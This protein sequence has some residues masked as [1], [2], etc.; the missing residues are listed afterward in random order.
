MFKVPEEHR[1]KYVPS[2][3]RMSAALGNNGLFVFQYKGY[4][5]RCIASNG[6]GWEHV[7]VTI[8]RNRCPSWEVMCE[9]KDMFWDEEDVV[10]QFHPKKSEYKNLHE[11]CLHLWRECGKNIKTPPKVFV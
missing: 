11:H 8:D 10:V 2:Y 9:V 5:V 4:E 6:G 3:G 1:V 7:S